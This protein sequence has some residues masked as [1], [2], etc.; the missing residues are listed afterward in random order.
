MVCKSWHDI[1][2]FNVLWHNFYEDDFPPYGDSDTE[3]TDYESDY[4]EYSGDSDSVA[5]D[6]VKSTKS[7]G[8]SEDVNWKKKY[9]KKYC[10]LNPKPAWRK[11]A[12]DHDDILS[13]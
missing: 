9:I 4:E 10:H 1:G 3:M 11:F 2:S 12:D 7:T 13:P 8:E 5:E 6:Y